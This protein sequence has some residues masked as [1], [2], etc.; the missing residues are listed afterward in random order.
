MTERCAACGAPPSPTP[1]CPDCGAPADTVPRSLRYGAHEWRPGDLP[2][3]EMRRRLARRLQ[4]E[5]RLVE[6]WEAEAAAPAVRPTAE[7]VRAVATEP[8][9]PPGPPR[10]AVPVPVRPPRPAP[11][12]GSGPGLEGLGWWI[13]GFLLLAGATFLVGTAWGALPPLARAALEVSGLLTV[14]AG[15][16]RGG[17]ALRLRSLA[18]GRRLA[19]IGLATTGVASVV[20]AVEGPTGAGL[21]ALALASAG[22]AAIAR[23]ARRADLVSPP[24]WALL[25][26]LPA[27]PALAPGLAWPAVVAA[28]TLLAAAVRSA[29]VE[30]RAARGVPAVGAAV[31][32]AAATAL[33]AFPSTGPA[34]GWFVLPVAG[35]LLVWIDAARTR[36]R[37]LDAPAFG[38]PAPVLGLALAAGALAGLPVATRGG[39][40]AAFAGGVLGL[41]LVALL[42]ARHR[43]RFLPVVAAVAALF[44]PA[45]GLAAAGVRGGGD[46]GGWFSCALLAAPLLVARRHPDLRWVWLVAAG[47]AAAVAPSGT[48]PAL[49]GGAGWAFLAL[50]VAARTADPVAA[51]VGL[52]GL[53]AGWLGLAAGWAHAAAFIPAGW[54]ALALPASVLGHALGRRGGDGH[55]AAALG[56]VLSAAG[57][58]LAAVALPVVGVGRLLDPGAAALAAGAL[59]AVAFGVPA[60]LR[61]D[62]ALTWAALPAVGAAA[63]L[64]RPVLGLHQDPVAGLVL[65]ACAASGAAAL[66]AR[67]DRQAWSRLGHRV[68][69][70][71]AGVEGWL[72]GPLW[73]VAQ[74]SVVV[75]AGAAGWEAALDRPGR[76]VGV[77]AAAAG[78]AVVQAWLDQRPA[79]RAWGATAAVLA[80][81][82]ATGVAVRWTGA[83]PA[84]LAVGALGALAGAGRL[85]PRVESGRGVDAALAG[86]TALITAGVWAGGLP[87]L[88]GV[89]PG[90]TG[91]TGSLVAGL[92]TAA[93][94]LPLA[95]GAAGPR[96]ARAAAWPAVG[97]VAGAVALAVAPHLDGP[98]GV[99]VAAAVVAAAAA[100]SASAARRGDR[101]RPLDAPLRALGVG[102][103]VL[104]SLAAAAG[105]SSGALLAP[106]AA[107]AVWLT[108]L[109]GA[110]DRRAPRVGPEGAVVGAGVGL[111]ALALAHEGGRRVSAAPE[112][113]AT[114]AAAVASVLAAR[115]RGRAGP[116]PTGAGSWA[117]WALVAGGAVP[118]LV[119]ATSPRHADGVVAA[120]TWGAAAAVALASPGPVLVALVAAAARGV[121][122]LGPLGLAGVAAGVAWIG[123]G[124]RRD[125]GGLADRT[126]SGVLVPGALVI[127][128]GAVILAGLTDAP[129]A[130]VVA[131]LAVGA[132]GPVPSGWR[133]PIA[134]L[135]PAL[136][137]ALGGATGPLPSLLLAGGAVGLAGVAAVAPSP[138]W[139]EDSLLPSPWSR[140]AVA[141]AALAVVGASG[142]P[143]ALAAALVAVS[144]TLLPW[145]RPGRGAGALLGAVAAAAAGLAAPL[146]AA[147]GP[148]LVPGVALV[149]AL[150]GELA[151][152]R[153][154]HD[155]TAYRALGAAAGLGVLAG[156]PGHPGLAVLVL[157]AAALAGLRSWWRRPTVSAA[158]AAAAWV[159]APVVAA[160]MSATPGA[161]DVL[162]VLGAGALAVAAPD[163]CAALP[164]AH[165]RSAVPVLRAVALVA[166]VVAL[167]LAA[168]GPAWSPGVFV[169]A[170]ATWALVHARRR[171][172]ASL[173]LA[174]GAVD[175]AVVFG[176]A[177]AGA[178]EPTFHV[179]PFAVTV[180]ILSHHFRTRLPA[181]A[182]DTL[183]WGAAGV[184]YATALVR[185]LVAPDH[186]LPAVLIGLVGLGAGAAAGIR[187]WVGSAAS[188]LVAV[189]ALQATRFGVAHQVGLGVVLTL[190]GV[191]VLGGT[192]ALGLRGRRAAA[193]PRAPAPAA[194]AGADGVPDTDP[195]V[196]SP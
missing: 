18:A 19:A 90:W 42:A 155:A 113:G 40:P 149:G 76:S 27:V 63:S 180:A 116:R 178:W 11:P 182:V 144:V 57:V 31:F 50:G 85:L 142:A 187:P 92:A 184:L 146:V 82:V 130:P 9:E 177:R 56:R 45:A 10:F 5:L 134:L 102:C 97:A 17:A 69:P 23:A 28:A 141:A 41:G 181:P 163:L 36:W 70:S 159:V 74:A 139:Y 161:L 30:R 33:A 136:V 12:P 22:A 193:D 53:A 105:T 117:V 150:L 26:V 148:W 25:A 140:L 1:S 73:R 194:P 108:C 99:A 156:A 111:A 79:A 38:R 135:A 190:A 77:A 174:F 123:A 48:G 96:A 52:A 175:G 122:T 93:P 164:E 120:V 32:G 29:I 62:E 16:V 143:L 14:A 173:L 72:A 112:L 61:R 154:R 166:P 110:A 145:V 86:G 55:P 20:A 162:G 124:L 80:G 51:A 103:A 104:A 64:V 185:M 147:H 160:R 83:V 59:V 131:V 109:A 126:R 7:R 67:R 132:L 88:L 39:D 106:G 167:A 89:G 133:A 168:V 98:P 115:G 151:A 191:G 137:A 81:A 179:L 107:L 3:P 87:P 65:G 44:V 189:V 176:L 47:A 114:V 43:E 101:A 49:V 75:L 152:D 13:G 186:V 192:V 100:M 165:R 6:R 46:P 94:F 35:A 125:D 138:R 34:V 170:A 118:A 188:F 91:P 129:A 68:S 58:G 21:L 169:G 128:S 196:L 84:V 15:L 54:A 153:L 195:E 60:A 66:L 121:H 78:L 157:G 24:G 2:A 95:L 158:A 4:A 119:A 171:D 127:G 172:P 71:G 183:S 37:G 8:P